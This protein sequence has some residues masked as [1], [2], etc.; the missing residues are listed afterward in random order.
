MRGVRG[1]GKWVC[2]EF[3][4]DPEVNEGICILEERLARAVTD[5]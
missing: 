4:D 2:A 1:T 5:A 3:Y